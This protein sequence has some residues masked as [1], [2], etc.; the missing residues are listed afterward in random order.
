MKQQ[1]KVVV[2]AAVVVSALFAA[3]ILFRD[4]VFPGVAQAPAAEGERAPAAPVVPAPADAG[5]EAVPAP[6]SPPAADGT[7]GSMPAWMADMVP[8]PPAGASAAAGA[9]AGK[10]A[11]RAARMQAAL[12]SLSRL[13]ASGKHTDPLE[14]DKV[15]AEVQ[16]ANGSNVLQGIR[17]DVLRENLRVAARMQTVANELQALQ[18]RSAGQPPGPELQAEVQRKLDEVQALQRELRMDFYAADRSA[19]PAVKP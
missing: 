3:G 8:K 17:L 13:Q 10:D 6:A 4:R 12:Q 1:W 2:G 19:A 7:A 9:P 5:A 16:R 14:V 11:E 15:L 18:Q